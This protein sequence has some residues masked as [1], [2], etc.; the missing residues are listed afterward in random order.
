MW[1]NG[2]LVGWW[3]ER[4]MAQPLWKPIGWLLKKLKIELPY[5]PATPLM[6]IDPGKLRAEGL[7][8]L[9]TRVLSSII[10]NGQKME[11]TCVST[12]GRTGE[13]IVVR[14]YDGI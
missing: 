2:N 14:P 8:Y 5:Y 11:T 6:G 7:R 12:Y 4:K 10:H 9:H 3:W 13:Q 1:R